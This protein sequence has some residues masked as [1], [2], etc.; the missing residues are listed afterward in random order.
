MSKLLHAVN[1]A[2]AGLKSLALAIVFVLCGASDAF[3]QPSIQC[4]TDNIRVDC[5]EEMFDFD[6]V[7]T[8]TVSGSEGYDVAITYVDNQVNSNNNPCRRIFNRTYNVD[9]TNEAGTISLMCTQTIKV[10][11]FEAP[12][13]VDAPANANYQCLSEVPAF[14]NL[15]A[16]D[17]CGDEVVVE[18]LQEAF[19]S[20]D[21]LICDQVSTPQGPGQDWAVWINGLYSS[22]LASTDWYRWR[23]TPS[24][25]FNSN[26]QARLVGTVEAINNPANGWYVDMTMMNGVNWSTWSA[27]G[28]L[29][30]DNLGQSGSTHTSWSFYQLVANFSRLQGFGAFAGS[31]LNLSHQPANY[32]YGFQFGNG[33]NNRNSNNGGSGW[34][35]YNGVIGETAVSGHGDVTIDMGCGTPGQSNEA[36]FEV[37]NR[38]WVAIDA[39]NNV[40][41]YEQVITVEDTVAPT[42]TNCPEGFSWECSATVP[43]AIPANEILA[44]DNCGG[45]VNVVYVGEQ[46]T[47]NFPCNYSI[48]HT[49][50]ADDECAN[51]AFCTYTIS[52]ADITPPVLTVPANATVQCNAEVEALLQETATATDNCTQDLQ[53]NVQLESTNDGNDC[54]YTYTRIFTVTDACGNE[55]TATQIINV[56]DTTAP[57]LNVPANATVQCNAEVDA[58]LAIPATATDNCTQ[59]LVVSEEVVSSNDGND[60]AYTYTR[61]FTVS[62]A[63]GNITT[64]TQVIEVRDTE[65]PSFVNVAGPYMV[66]CNDIYND[67]WVRPAATD[68]CDSDLT[69]TYSD[70]LT[71][72]GC[73]GTIHRTVTITDNCDNSATATFVI[74]IQDNTAPTITSIPADQQVECDNVPSAPGVEAVIASDNCGSETAIYA[75]YTEG[76]NDNVTVTFEQQVLSGNC[77]GNYTILWI[78]TATDYC[79]NSSSD[80]T[81]ITV[82]DTTAPVFTVPADLV[83][84]CNQ[85]IPD[86][87]VVMATDNCSSDEIAATSQDVITQGSCAANY[88]ISRVYTAA[89]ACGNVS[90]QTQTITIVDTTAP[91]FEGNSELSYECSLGQE[92]P[93]DTPTVTDNCSEYTVN[94]VDSTYASGCNN[95]IVRTWTA[96]DACGNTSSFVQTISIVDTTAPV[97]DYVVE[98]ERPCDDYMGIYA[99]AFDACDGDVTVSWVSDN[100]V[101]GQCPFRLVRVY[102]AQDECGN[103]VQVEQIIALVDNVA[104]VANNPVADIQIECG[105][106][107]PTYDPNWTDN[108]SPTID[109]GMTSSSTTDGCITTVVEVYTASDICQNS[110]SVTR[111]ITIVDTTN[112]VIVNMPENITVACGTELPVASA[113]TASDLCDDDVTITMS[114]DMLPGGCPNSYTVM[115]VY[116]ATDDCGNQ[117]VETQ[118]I[119]VIDEVAPLFGEGNETSFSY[120]CTESIPVIEPSATDECGDVTL[121]YVDSDASGNTCQSVFSRVWT[122]TDACGNPS[123]FTQVITILDTVAPVISGEPEVSRPCDDYAGIYVTANDA[124]SDVESITFTESFVSG[125]CAG[126]V[127]RSYTAVDECGNMSAEFIQVIRLTDEVAPVCENAPEAIEVECGSEIPAYSPIWTDQCDQDLELT[128]ETFNEVAGCTNV[129]TT[130]YTATDDCDNTSTVTR[131]VTIV[132][133][134]APVASN[135]P[136]N[137]SIACADFTGVMNI[138]APAFTDVCDN[139]VTVVMTSTEEVNGCDRIFTITWTATDNCNNSTVVTAVI[140]VFDNVAPVFTSVPAGGQYNCGE[141]I[142]YGMAEALDACGLAVVSYSDDTTYTC[143]QSY[144]IVRT[145][146]A[147]DD[148]NN[149]ATQTTSYIVTDEE[150]P[151]FTFFPVDLTIECTDA[152]PDAF[153]SASDNCDTEVD[154][155]VVEAIVYQDNCLVTYER[156]YT[157]ED[158]CGN[159]TVQTQTIYKRD[160]TAPVFAGDATVNLSCDEYNAE[161]VYVTASDNCNDYVITVDSEIPSGLGCSAYSVTRVY[162][163]VDACGNTSFFTQNIVITDDVAPTA[164]IVPMDDVI[165]CTESPEPANVQFTDNCD[166]NVE[167]QF[168]VEESSD[169]CSTTYT[170]TWSATDNCGNVTTVDQVIVKTDNV[171]PTFDMESTEVIVECGSE[172]VIPVPTATDECDSDVEVTFTTETAAGD[173][174]SN[175]TETI[176]YTAVDNCNNSSTVT[177]TVIHVDTTSPVWV[178]ENPEYFTYECGQGAPVVTPEAFEACGDINYTFVDSEEVTEGCVSSFVRTWVAIDACN[179]ASEEF[180]QFISFEDTTAPMM[181]NCPENETVDCGAE[182]PAV[183]EVSAYDA[184]D[185]SVEVTMTEECIGCP[186]VDGVTTYDLYTPVRSAGNPCAYPYDWAMALFAVPSNNF[187]WYQLDSSTP[188]QVVYN[189]DGSVNFSGRLVNAVI[190]TGGFDFNVTFAQGENWADWVAGPGARSFKA[191]C[192]GEDGNYQDWMYYIMQ[193]DAGVEL[194]GWGSLEGSLVNLT[195]APS[196]NYFGFQIGDGANNYN[197]DYGAGGW[198]NYSGVIAYEG[199]NISSGAQSGTGDFAFRIDNCP[200]Y[201]IVRTW[202]A[203]DCSD[204]TASCTQ[205]ITFSGQDNGAMIVVADGNEEGRDGEISIVGIMPNPANNHSV[206]SFTSTGTGKLTLE[207]LDMTGRVVGSLFNNEVEAGVVYTADFDA[208]RLSTGIYMVRLSSGTDF[209]VQRL[210][211][212]K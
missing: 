2:Q 164:L 96:V 137:Q 206:I 36:C 116:R 195:H 179:N 183:A 212:Q 40:A 166:D 14:T 55:S 45:A 189:V 158:N 24:I 63:C 71:S 149:Q 156:T 54:I 126:T 186:T 202:T 64:G 203:T 133:T 119:T 49:Y 184:C 176:V 198:F 210:Q 101:S 160:T 209:E 43:S 110:T 6:Q 75:A 51:R 148:C 178:S 144:T 192:G 102:S 52:V 111:T 59:N 92:V 20:D 106:E 157:A 1:L 100:F 33:A 118:T 163:A 187:K 201:S 58:L 168:M 181:L 124:C 132:D 37:T 155:T 27:N 11:D 86:A 197:G 89:D 107:I 190:P 39:C 34:F 135:A 69:Y 153:A 167:V 125:V 97:I 32:S 70:E 134:T 142:D 23:G 62:D 140:T 108:C 194:I 25:R 112:P 141:T 120:E 117:A 85:A 48:T 31:R 114:E 74:Y 22:G 60:C 154:V 93:V 94:Y 180:I 109:A 152:L 9:F 13:F 16:T 68:N 35:F 146:V 72:G 170:F 139:D 8:V 138:A 200:E 29:Y 44:T 50:A 123:T 78:W 82:T 172:A 5:L 193:A 10:F 7:G 115:R 3:A 143:P 73:L 151:V 26:G 47:G 61:S 145:W 57:E 127:L 41:E 121:T 113:V 83:I 28:G 171:A 88:T 56:V 188:S 77:P 128:M 174:P 46:V 4:P 19:V 129:V 199:Q 84:E 66:E 91:S 99:T 205:I 208:N 95:Y 211:I 136:E 67:E 207:V 18:Q 191:D 147:T 81:V 185:A 173:C 79:E 122:A 87:E 130:V 21:T 175:Y 196:N 42:F 30:M 38:R 104:P 204:N 17:G 80:T 76:N 65:N 177:I 165:Y 162:K 161:N 12:V 53:I 159:T 105:S 150:A 15:L 169:A 131:V 182:T 98:I 90:T 103:V